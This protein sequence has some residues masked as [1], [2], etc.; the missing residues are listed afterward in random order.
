[1]Y[2]LKL[3]TFMLKPELF[4]PEPAP[5]KLK[6]EAVMLKPVHLELKLVPFKLSCCRILLLFHTRS[7]VFR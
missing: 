3:E 5:F 1:M 7:S 4:K 6:L 2:G